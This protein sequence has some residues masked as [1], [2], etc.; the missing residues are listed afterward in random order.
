L[1]LA[2]FLQGFVPCFSG[3]EHQFLEAVFVVCTAIV[4]T[5]G[6]LIPRRYQRLKQL[7]LGLGHLVPFVLVPVCSLDTAKKSAIPTA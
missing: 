2:E 6:A 4:A 7:G 5:G 1:G 3:F